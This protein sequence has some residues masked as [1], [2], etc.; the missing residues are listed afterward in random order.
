MAPGVIA[1]S[2]RSSHVTELQESRCFQLRIQN[3]PVWLDSRAR[4]GHFQ[5][6]SRMFACLQGYVVNF[7]YSALLSQ[8]FD[9][10]DSF[11]AALDSPTFRPICLIFTAFHF[12][13][14]PACTAVVMHNV[15]LPSHQF[16]LPTVDYTFL[17]RFPCGSPATVNATFIL[18]PERAFPSHRPSHR[19]G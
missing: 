6:R 11:P 7:K 13:Q 12:L 17:S 5:L 18:L 3:I 4:Q 9:F 1:K 8:P 14:T 10:A 19:E 16:S 2:I 15:L